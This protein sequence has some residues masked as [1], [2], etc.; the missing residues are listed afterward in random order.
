MLR[1]HRNLREREKRFLFEC[2]NDLIFV[3]ICDIVRR[4][5]SIC[6]HLPETRMPRVELSWKSH[7]I[8]SDA[9]NMPNKPFST[10][11]DVQIMEH[12]FDVTMFV[13]VC[14]YGMR[15]NAECMGMKAT[16]WIIALWK[17]EKCAP[18]KRLWKL[19]ITKIPMQTIFMLY[20]VR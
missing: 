5:R 13:C 14:V 7:C 1:F 6:S 19:L 11:N 4:I 20:F 8:W 18:Q 2:S 9:Y 15:A 10:E 16:L 3:N 17:C 12:I